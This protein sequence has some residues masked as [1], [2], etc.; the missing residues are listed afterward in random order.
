MFQLFGTANP[1]SVLLFICSICYA[2]ASVWSVYYI[3]KNRREKMSKFFYF[4]SALAAILN[5]IFTFYFLS[6]GLIG[7]PT[8]I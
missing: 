3:F 1:I 7:I 4:H 5:L 8:W 6:N 2:L